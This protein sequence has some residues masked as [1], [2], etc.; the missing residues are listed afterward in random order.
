MTRPRR[1]EDAH[2]FLVRLRR[3]E[4]QVHGL[5]RMVESAASV[6]DILTQV[7]SVRVALSGFGSA[8]LNAELALVAAAYQPPTWH[9]STTPWLC[10]PSAEPRPSVVARNGFRSANG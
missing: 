6:V 10:S 9:G 5:Q 4:G 8:I 2:E 7:A 3:V 1:P